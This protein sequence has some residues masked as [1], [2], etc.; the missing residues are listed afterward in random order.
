MN[1]FVASLPRRISASASLLLCSLVLSCDN[2]K[3]PNAEEEQKTK[4]PDFKAEALANRGARADTLFVTL[5]AKET[6][7]DPKLKRF[8]KHPHAYFYGSG[9]R[10][11]GV[12]VGDVDGDGWLDIFVASGPSG[13]RLYRQVAPL[14]FQDITLGTGIEKDQAWSRGAAM[15]DIDNDG[16]LDIYVTNY[17]ADNQLFINQGS[18][19]GKPVVFTEEAFERLVNVVDASVMPSFCDYDRDGDLDMYLITN[20]YRWP[21]HL[22]PPTQAQLIETVNG[23]PA[24]RGPFRKYFRLTDWRPHP[25]GTGFE[26]KWDRT[27]RPDFLFENDGTGKFK[28][29]TKKAGMI[30]GN[31]RGLSAT[32]WDYN[33]DGLPDLY[34]AN[35]WMDRDFLYQNNGDGT[36]KD[37]IE[38]AVPYTPMFTMGSDAGDLNND[39][40]I[41][42]IAADMSGTTH[43]KRKISMGTMQADTIDFMVN[44]RPQQNMR[45]VVYLNTGTPRLLEAAYLTHMANSD[46]SWAVKID[47]LDNDGFADVFVTNGMEQNIRELE[48]APSDPKTG[49][50]RSENN[51]VFRN[52]G[53]LKFHENG[54]EWGLD[55][56]GFSLSAASADFDRDG[57]IDLFVIQRDEPPILHKNTS[58]DASVVV[59]LK[60]TKSNRQGIGAKVRIETTSG[61][62]VR[63]ITATRGYLSSDEPVAH[64]GLG[65]EKTIKRLTVEWPSGHH[66]VFKD[67]KANQRILITE[68]NEAVPKRGTPATPAPLFAKHSGL[69]A[70]AHKEK[71]FDD[72]AVQ[73]LLP[74]QLS[75]LGPGIATGDIDGDG[76]QDF[77]MGG[78]AGDSTRVVINQ[79]GGKYAPPRPLSDTT[80]FED[81]GLVLFDADGDG[82]RDLYV[83]SGG[84]EEGISL[85]DRLYLNDGKGRFTL[86]PEGT[87]PT[88][89]DSGGP[90]AVADIDH[91]G[92]LDLF[93]GGRVVPG[94]YPISPNSRLLINEGGRFTD[95]TDAANSG[96]R[97]SGL[98]TSAAFA[99]LDGD[100]W[101]DL[102]L[103]REWGAIA[104][105]RNEEGKFTDLTE[106]SKLAEITGWW[107][108]VT[109]GDVDGDGDL[110]LVATN[111]GYNTKYHASKEHPALI[112]YGSFGTDTMRIVEA[113]YEDG[114]LYPVRGRSCSCRAIP[115]LEDKFGTF[116]EFAMAELPEIYTPPVI[117]DAVKFSANTL[118]SGVFLNNG[119]DGF[120][121]Q[122]LPRLA[123]IS[124]SFG[125]V[126]NDFDGDGII[127]LFLAQN[128]FGPQPETGRMSGGVSLF[129]RGKGDGSFDPVWPRESGIIITEDATAAGIADLD[130]DSWPD[131]LVASNNGPARS[132]LNR[133]S[134]GRNMLRLDLRGAKGN[135]D[136]IGAQVT[137]TLADGSK[138][139]REVTAGGSYL[140]QASPSLFFGS[141]AQK[142]T[143]ISVRWPGGKTSV[144]DVPAG[145]KSMTISQPSEATAS[146]TP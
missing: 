123:Q 79:G 63:Q 88:E 44:A 107:N 136:A 61:Q 33:D 64:F 71:E 12:A 138:Q 13:N 1:W 142:I 98:V 139:I 124:P 109:P 9:M 95:G 40:K 20:E 41:D 17:D 16:D 29:V 42:F 97:Q 96:L 74:N 118:A 14:K 145:Q 91:D 27:G 80:A 105:F 133:G 36:F 8:P 59:A 119:S 92:D 137:V 72:F 4:N 110:D 101:Q 7:I 21:P 77:V 19:K 3:P 26:V 104:Y 56:F 51:V 43:Y 75:Q 116:H 73:P 144:H 131:L 30:H 103:A 25:S 18:Q 47:D 34:V 66:Q 127:D 82:D 99:D 24:I 5:T 146:V 60:G 31:G 2:G 106:S 140:T 108:G 87:I 46:W 94:Q 93:V 37:V 55:Y 122:K 120:S 38:E 90:V 85:Q 57:D 48:G 70:L 62:Q 22:P 10:A 83:A 32:W 6:G 58:N 125:T 68:P 143:K 113:E 111:F 115:H 112:Y 52:D 135:L 114:V 128:F 65:K 35:D 102:V 50:L 28:E 130:G 86:A 54:K 69:R 49:D 11:G 84:V 45:N 121:F 53:D 76:D 15:V 134:S 100:G 89:N 129:L 81:M 132:F 141:G 117:E 23:K 78:A 126:L 39:G 67:L